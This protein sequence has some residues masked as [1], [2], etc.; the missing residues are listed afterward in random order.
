VTDVRG[1]WE[2]FALCDLECVAG[3]QNSPDF[4]ASHYTTVL[5]L[6]QERRF[7]SIRVMVKRILF[8]ARMAIRP[9]NRGKQR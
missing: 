9:T 7:G 6:F 1:D 8:R 2:G 4:A 5:Q 3:I